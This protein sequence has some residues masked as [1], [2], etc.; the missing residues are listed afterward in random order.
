MGNAATA[1]QLPAATAI[2]ITAHDATIRLEDI[3]ASL[4]ISIILRNK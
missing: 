2:A 4:E 1:Y 3:T